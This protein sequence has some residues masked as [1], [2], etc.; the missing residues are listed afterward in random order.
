MKN[1]YFRGKIKIKIITSLS[2][3]LYAHLLTNTMWQ[4]YRVEST[5]CV[6]TLIQTLYRN[7]L[8]YV[9]Q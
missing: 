4:V 2:L 9:V 7:M 5:Q 1:K 8:Y 3:D 6:N